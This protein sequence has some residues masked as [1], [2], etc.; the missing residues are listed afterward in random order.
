MENSGKRFGIAKTELM[1][2]DCYFT[3]Y[4]LL[5]FH[6]WARTDVSSVRLF[7]FQRVQLNIECDIFSK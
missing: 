1:L 6:P 7:Q 4:V 2:E 5:Y 3:V